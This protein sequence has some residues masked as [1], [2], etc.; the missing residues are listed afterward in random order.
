MCLH[1]QTPRS[2]LGAFCV[3]SN[4]AAIA[5]GLQAIA[6]RLDSLPVHVPQPDQPAAFQGVKVTAQNASQSTFCHRLSES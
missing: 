6:L 1:C 2:F 3:I 5:S 4:V